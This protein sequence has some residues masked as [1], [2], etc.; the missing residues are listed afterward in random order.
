MAFGRCAVRRV[1]LADARQDRNGDKRQRGE[2]DDGSLAE[3]HDDERGHQR[4]ERLAEIAAD[5]KQRLRKTMA[6]ARCRARH[7]R[8]LGMEDRRSDANQRHRGQKQGIAAP[9]GQQRQAEKR[10]RMASGSE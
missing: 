9:E 2:P 4:P 7:T 8:S 3:R 5:L 1:P 6:S 10:E